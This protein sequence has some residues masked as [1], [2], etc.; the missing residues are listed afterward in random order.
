MA[1]NRK[2]RKPKKGKNRPQK[3]TFNTKLDL[4]NNLGEM[5]VNSIEEDFEI[6]ETHFGPIKISE[7]AV[8][9]GLKNKGALLPISSIGDRISED[10]DLEILL[11]YER[12]NEKF[13]EEPFIHV[14]IADCFKSLHQ[15][16][17]YLERLKENFLNYKGY[18]L[19]DIEYALNL[20]KINIELYEFIFGKEFNIHHQYPDFRVFDPYTVTHFYALKAKYYIELQEYEIARSCV[21]IVKQLDRY[22][23]KL[24]SIMVSYASDPSFKRKAKITRT[25]FVLVILAIIVGIILGV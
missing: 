7:G 13:P 4:Q 20:K 3:R 25:L 1:K 8:V 14:Q 11:E 5:L 23:A 9:Y 6:L 18:P 24:L 16:E 17:K 12:L 19:V 2:K 21:D 10:D 22:K 15:E